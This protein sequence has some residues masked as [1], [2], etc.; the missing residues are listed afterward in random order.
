MKVEERFDFRFANE[1]NIAINTY[2]LAVNID[3][4]GMDYP[5]ESELTKT[6]SR[7]SS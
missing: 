1:S 6:L 7:Y 3:K 4:A 2:V 5:T